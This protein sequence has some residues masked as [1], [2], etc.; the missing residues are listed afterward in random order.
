M[1]K[2]VLLLANKDVTLLYY[3]QEIIKKL[4]E[5]K[6]EVFVSFPKS[7]KIDYFEK[8]LK[9]KY[10]NVEMDGH[11]I[12][13]LKDMKIITDYVKIINKVKPNIVL[14][15]TIKPNVYGGIACRIKHISYIENIT[16]L[17]AALE[18]KGIIQEIAII[19]YKVALKKAKCVFVQ[20]KEN[21]K[22]MQTKIGYSSKY[23]L[24]PGS[25]V[26]LEK[27]E[28]LKYPNKKDKI[29]FLFISRIRKEKG[30]DLYI[31]TA[32]YIKLKYPNTE[33]CVLGECEQG[34]DKKLKKID[35]EGII[36]Y[37]GRQDNIVPF[38][39]ESW[40]TI[41]PSY[42]PEGMSNVLLESS[43]TGRPVITTNR[44]GCK[45]TVDNKKTGYIIETK[46]LEMLKNV[47][48]Q[49]INLPYC[50]KVSMGEAARKKMEKE[51]DRNIVVK[52]YMNE[53]G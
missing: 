21:L 43:A 1:G 20:N 38:L 45:E 14:T 23:K 17:G 31:E 46:N 29:R 28:L 40:C 18:N 39:K 44:S 4:V 52:A 16:G 5:E 22:F 8:E 33:F 41:H 42:Y 13:P 3:R 50:E 51:F 12:N 49:F 10:V 35:E 9:C 48:E 6:Y 47:T 2:R 11:G 30:I 15:Y 19:L 36:K 26:N 24:I 37:Y 25:G 53:I 32:K 7:D 34:Y 27:F